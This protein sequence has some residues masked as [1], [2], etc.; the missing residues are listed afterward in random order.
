M[1]AFEILAV[2]ALVVANGFFVSVEFALV[3]VRRARIEYLVEQ[4]KPSAKLVRKLLDQTDRILAAAQ[5]GITMASL[6]LGWIGESTMAQLIQPLFDS[7]PHV[8]ATGATHALATIFAFALITALHIV[9]GEQAP[10]IYSI[11]NPEQISMITVRAILIFELIFRPFIWM[12]DR[13]SQAA[14]QVAGVRGQMTEPGQMH[15]LE[16]LRMHFI[17]VYQRGLLNQQQEEMLHSVIEFTQ[18][19]AKDVMTPRPELESLEENQMIGDLLDATKESGHS[20]FPVYREKPEN[21][22]GYLSINDVLKVIREE[23]SALRKPIKALTHPI[24]YVPENKRVSA[25]FQEMQRERVP[26]VAVVNE[27]S[28]TEG[29]VTLNGLAEEIVGQLERVKES[30]PQFERVDRRTI[31]VDGQLRMDHANEQL[32]LKLPERGEYQTIAGF[33]LYQLQRIPKEGD[34]LRHE[35]L[36]LIVERM[37]GPRIDKVLIHGL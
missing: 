30:E 25:L 10:K 35:H 31:R 5:L 6:A 9:L 18:L 2:V 7:L 23:A 33:I 26:M 22:V 36:R 27:F 20:R 12:L 16:E 14:L 19:E 11:R 3:S 17:D 4:G 15:S 29:I 34:L 1:V 21:V 24:K 13:A 8:L 28:D 32:K 37:D